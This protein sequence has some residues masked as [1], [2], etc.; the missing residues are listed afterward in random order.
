MLGHTATGNPVTKENAVIGVRFESDLTYSKDES[1]FV[2]WP[3]GFADRILEQMAE[4]EGGWAVW[5]THWFEAK[6]LA[7][8]YEA[9]EEI[10]AVYIVHDNTLDDWMVW[11]NHPDPLNQL[12]GL[13][14]TEHGGD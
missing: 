7:T 2:E 3:H 6:L 1:N 11:T 13:Q 14:K 9:L 10:D 5:C 12:K 4:E 8:Y